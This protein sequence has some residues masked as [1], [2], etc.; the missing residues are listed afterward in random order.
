MRQAVIGRSLALITVLVLAIPAIAQDSDGVTGA[1]RPRVG[2]VLGGGGARGAAHIGVLR[3]LERHRVPIDAIAGTSMGAI[4]GGLYASGKS[5][6]ELEELITTIDWVGTMSDTP[7]R[8]HLSFRRKQDDA[9][10]PI[11]LELGIKGHELTLPMGVIQGQKLDL[12]LRELTIDVAGTGDFDELPIPFRAVASDLESGEA[13]VIGQGDLALAIRASMTVPGVLAPVERDGRLLVDGG[14]VG[15]LPINVARDMDVDIIIAVDVE[16]PLYKGDE[17]DSVLAISE[18]MLTI[19]IHNETLRQID[20]LGE[21]DILIRPELG[22]YAS[23]DFGHIVDTIEPGRSAALAVADQLRGIAL[24]DAD[25]AAHVAARTAPAPADE[26]LAFVRVEHD[27]RL[28]AEILEARLDTSV[29]DAVDP[30]RLA[31]D[32]DRLYGLNLY[33]KVGY[34]LVEED[35][36]TGVEFVARSKSW[37]PSTLKFSLALED[38]F[39]GSTGFNVGARLTKSGLNPYGGEWRNDIQLGSEPRLISELYQ[40]FGSE[41]RYFVAPRIDMRQ[42][43]IKAFLGE[44]PIARLR[45]SEIEG[46]FDLGAELASWGEF[47]M[48]TFRG[49]G[50]ARVKV[51]EPS[52]ANFDFDTGG[53]QAALHI[54]TLDNAQFPSDGM[55]ADV[56][57]RQFL[58]AI[59][60]DSRF[61]TIESAF[62][63][64]WHSGKNT[65]QVGL[66][67]ATTLDAD[68][69]IQEYFPL[70]GFLR[71]SGLER[72]EISGPHSALGKLVYY[73]RIGES[74]GGLFDVPV[75][76]GGSV[77]AG[78]VWQTRQDISFDSM[79]V[80]GS[81]FVGL[82]SYIGPIYLAA[83]LAEGGRT[84]LYLFIGS[85][86]R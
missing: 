28:K 40:P 16:F 6:D 27:G 78:N 75:Y 39:E 34:R 30:E 3:E 65:F 5:V 59:G 42:S 7:P 50:K 48:G 43:N 76:I 9:A 12:L 71:L 2:L 14:I 74:A 82:D 52:I 62:A 35:G 38:D 83:G 4:I 80:N 11:D 84:N 10:Y 70:G 24:D 36:A 19:L 8:R 54:D 66:E 18:Q 25:Y 21:D 60:A 69:A 56:R 81:I 85:P 46:G 45:I 86:P 15:N 47:R 20:T 44:T 33:E 26:P 32:A 13:V 17:L 1:D 41:A 58:P 23:G 55:R 72:G 53:V 73:R 68:A 57:W 49:F 22:T 37:G 29:G 51:G 63:G 31:R 79:H 61:D 64:Y 77:E 67:Y